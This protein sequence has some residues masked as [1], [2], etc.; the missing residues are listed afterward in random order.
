MCGGVEPR[1][2]FA[3]ETRCGGSVADGDEDDAVVLVLPVEVGASVPEP[4]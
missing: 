4:L 1:G 3:G 2:A